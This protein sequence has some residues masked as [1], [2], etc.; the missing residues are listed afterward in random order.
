MEQILGGE[1]M[2]VKRFERQPEIEED[3]IQILSLVA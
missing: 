3:R 2:Q 1:M